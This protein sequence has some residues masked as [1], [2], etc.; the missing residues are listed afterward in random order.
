MQRYRETPAGH[1]RLALK[2]KKGEA[3]MSAFLAGSPAWSHWK[4]S[5]N[6]DQRTGNYESS[7]YTVCENQSAYSRVDDLLCFV[8]SEIKCK[9]AP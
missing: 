7:F 9:D 6:T 2:G 4:A 3:E 5:N 1:A 8:P